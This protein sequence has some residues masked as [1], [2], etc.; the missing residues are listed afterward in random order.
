M[1]ITGEKF[2][3]ACIVIDKFDKLPKSEIF[4]ELRKLDVAQEHIERLMAFL[5]TREFEKVGEMV[6]KESGGVKEIEELVRMCES[7]GFGEWVEFDPKI[8]RYA[9]SPPLF[10]FLSSLPLSPPLPPI[11]PSC[12]PIL[13]LL[14]LPLPLYPPLYPPPYPPSPSYPPLLSFLLLPFPCSLSPT[15]F[16]HS[17]FVTEMCRFSFFSSSLIPPLPTYS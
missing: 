5:G 15:P 3:K 2:T 6:G 16:S 9:N 14:I 4:D 10:T 1:G 8:V 17:L 11:L 12:P 7:Y 13:P